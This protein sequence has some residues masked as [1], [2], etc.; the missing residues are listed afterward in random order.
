MKQV[1]VILP[2]VARCAA[3]LSSYVICIYILR[4]MTTQQRIGLPVILHVLG[5]TSS[6]FQTRS[7]L[8]SVLRKNPNR[9]KFSTNRTALVY[10]RLA[11][12]FCN[13][14]SND[15]L[16]LSL[17]SFSLID[18]SNDATSSPSLPGPTVG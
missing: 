6:C 12:I 4:M 15:N 8:C 13:N 2:Q 7:P 10:K 18:S 17:E 1:D 11:N 5:D 14:T 16:L 9:P 3:V